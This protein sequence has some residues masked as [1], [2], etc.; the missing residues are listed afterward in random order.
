MSED[1]TA[2]E[3]WSLPQAG[4]PLA[5]DPR[6]HVSALP[7]AGRDGWGG[8]ARPIVYGGPA[9]LPSVIVGL[10][11]DG[12]DLPAGLALLDGPTG[13]ERGRWSGPESTPGAGGLVAI[14]RASGAD[15]RVAAA[16]EQA[17]VAHLGSAL[18]LADDA[19][20][21]GVPDVVAANRAP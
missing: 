17:R 3:L 2:E 13:A 12:D 21:D 4:L 6:I 18:T 5:P 19:D 16:T 7:P 15:V 10:H 14:V 11:D 9:G 1:G 8:P 20:T